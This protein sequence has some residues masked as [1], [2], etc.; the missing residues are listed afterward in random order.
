MTENQNQPTIEDSIQ[1]VD[2]AMQVVNT[3]FTEAENKS[4]S[5]KNK[6][7]RF[8][9]TTRGRLFRTEQNIRQL[10]YSILSMQKELLNLYKTLKEAQQPR[11]KENKNKRNDMYA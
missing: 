6:I 10:S 9:P 11:Q 3:Y 8:L 4:K 5:F 7:L 2:Q 1:E